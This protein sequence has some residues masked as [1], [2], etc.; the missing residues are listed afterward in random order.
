[1]KQIYGVSH[2]S[3]EANFCLLRKRTENY[4]NVI[5][6]PMKM[7]TTKKLIKLYIIE[8]LNLNCNA[9]NRIY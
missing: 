9:N 4:S 3:N 5:M 1:M 6:E 8:T 2:M 7:S